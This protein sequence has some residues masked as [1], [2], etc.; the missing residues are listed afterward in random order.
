VVCGLVGAVL[1][2]GCRFLVRDTPDDEWSLW[3]TVSRYR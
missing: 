3:L 2:C 1:P